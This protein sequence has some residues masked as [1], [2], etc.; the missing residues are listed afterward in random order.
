[1]G[2]PDHLEADTVA[3]VHIH[4]EQRVLLIVDFVLTWLLVVP[5]GVSSGASS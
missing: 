2:R 5:L 4:R 1:M 3:D